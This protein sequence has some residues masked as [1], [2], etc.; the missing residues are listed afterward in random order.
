[1]RL[2]TIAITG[3]ETR[4]GCGGKGARL[5]EVKAPGTWFLI[6]LVKNDEREGSRTMQRF[7]MWVMVGSLE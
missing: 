1:M 4:T 2:G 5:G 6:W 3:M 7:H